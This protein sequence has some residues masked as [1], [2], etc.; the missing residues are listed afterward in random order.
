MKYNVAR[1]IQLKWSITPVPVVTIGDFKLTTLQIFRCRERR[2][3]IIVIRIDQSCHDSR[4]AS[5]GL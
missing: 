4:N 5:E 1:V 3:L 2:R